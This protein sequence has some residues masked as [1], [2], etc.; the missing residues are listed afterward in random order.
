MRILFLTHYFYPE[1]NAPATR[2]RQ[3]TRRWVRAGH[4]VTVVT[5]AP[6]VP[7]GVVYEGYENR[8]QQ[9]EEVDGV[10]VVRVWTWLAANAGTLRRILN[11]VSFML[12]GTL[13]GLRV[14]R[15]DVVIATSPQFFCGWAGVLVAKLRRLPFV[16]EIRDLWPESI[17]AV[18]ALAESRWIRLLEW[19]ELRLYAAADRVVT[20]GEGY[21]RKLE[22]KGVPA[23]I[24]HLVPN[25]VDRALFRPDVD[26]AAV[27]AEYGLG[28]RSVCAYVGTIGMAAALDV[29][30][31]AA[32][33]LRDAGR[34]DVCLLLVGDGAARGELEER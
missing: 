7:S 25:G 23:A 32:R 18:G 1:G 14:R 31:R 2:V 34:D 6:N 21:R 22:E 13:A 8:W 15:P 30:L 20:V 28:E 24:I 9:R 29:A 12:T 33:R 4:D 16:L 11:Y 26:G 3:L 19:L 5:C 10:E 17:V 27:R